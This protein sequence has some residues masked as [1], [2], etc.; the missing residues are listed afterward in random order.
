MPT[1]TIAFFAGSLIPIHKFTL[2]ERPIGGTETGLI[3]LADELQD[4]G[5]EV[6]VFTSHS[7]PPPSSSPKY[8]PAS[9]MQFVQ[10]PFD[11][12]VLVQDWKPL[13]IQLPA[14]RIA[15]WTGDGADMFSNS[16][17]GDPRVFNRIDKFLAVSL[18]QAE[19]ISAASGFPR[20]K[21]GIIGNGV[22]LPWFEG[23]EPRQRERLIYASAPY[24]GLKLLTTLF[25]KIKTVR[26]NCEL[27]VFSG[28][29]LYDRDKAWEGPYAEEQKRIFKDL[30]KLDGVSLHE[31]ILP[32]DLARELM[33]SSVLVY[34]AIV[35][36][37]CCMVALEAQ[38]AGCPMVTSSLGSLPATVD[39]CGFVIKEPV[40]SEAF[41][42]NF[43]DA[44]TKL[45]SD[46][47][48]WSELSKRCLQRTQ[49]ENS[50]R[51]VRQRFVEVLNLYNP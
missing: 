26:P 24:R 6:T 50:W 14:K 2:N 4:S 8:V 9:L 1:K 46:D 34:P 20:E 45:L 10:K 29:N 19:S 15:F 5:Y 7:E 3:R 18:Y 22:Y 42:K 31:A 41:E 28:M 32:S 27:H 23:T 17:I 16:G 36:E 43:I 12:M 38:A 13:M 51:H 47:A 21:M 39:D 48:T 37:T 44:T 25:P 40:G 33:R 49:N 11:L 35:P 30:S